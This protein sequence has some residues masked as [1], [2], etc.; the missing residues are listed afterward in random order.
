MLLLVG[1]SELV[2]NNSEFKSFDNKLIAG[3]SSTSANCVGEF[4][5]ID[6]K[7]GCKESIE[8]YQQYIYLWF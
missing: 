1:L 4:L 5:I 6:G 7:S 2:V 8:Q 3:D